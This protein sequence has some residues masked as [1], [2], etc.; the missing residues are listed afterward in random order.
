MGSLGYHWVMG[1]ASP[2]G[3]QVKYFYRITCNHTNTVSTKEELKGTYLMYNTTSER[4]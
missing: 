3:T 4:V 2:T 1:T